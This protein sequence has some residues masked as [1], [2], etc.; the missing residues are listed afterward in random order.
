M[1]EIAG[2]IIIALVVLAL[3]PF[4]INVVCWCVLVALDVFF[5][6]LD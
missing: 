6:I 1:F 3:I 5:G 4:A 2:G